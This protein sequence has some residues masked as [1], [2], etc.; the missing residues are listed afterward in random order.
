MSE[1]L[2]PQLQATNA[3]RLLDTR[4]QDKDRQIRALQFERQELV[5]QKMKKESELSQILSK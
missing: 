4:I 1:H 3:I 2:I 5:T